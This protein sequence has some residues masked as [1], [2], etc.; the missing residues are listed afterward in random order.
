MPKKKK[1]RV[2]LGRKMMGRRNGLFGGV[3][4]KYIFVFKK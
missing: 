2:L 4:K 1:K 3:I